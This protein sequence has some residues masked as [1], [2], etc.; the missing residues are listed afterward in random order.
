MLREQYRAAQNFTITLLMS[1]ERCWLGLSD[2]H[3]HILKA[4]EDRGLFHGAE[5]DS[6]AKSEHL[7]DGNR[8][9]GSL[10]E[11]QNIKRA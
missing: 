8:V 6:I 1:I 9:C 11:M 7:V 4:N 2:F 5:V 3:L 10:A